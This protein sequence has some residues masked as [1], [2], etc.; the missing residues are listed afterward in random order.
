MLVGASVVIQRHVQS[1]ENFVL[2]CTFPAED[3]QGDGLAP[4]DTPPVNRYPFFVVLVPGFPY[5][6]V[7]FVGDSTVWNGPQG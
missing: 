3:E 5:L 1:S 4:L 6:C 7:L 2:M